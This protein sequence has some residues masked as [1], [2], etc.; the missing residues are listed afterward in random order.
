DEGRRRC[1]GS[2]PL[3]PLRP[4]EEPG[5]QAGQDNC[6][7][8]DQGRDHVDGP[9][10]ISISFT[11]LLKYR[12]DG[13]CSGYVLV[14]AQGSVSQGGTSFTA[15]GQGVVYSTD[16]THLQTNKTTA[17]ATRIRYNDSSEQKG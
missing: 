11:E 14:T 7:G 5:H 6:P 9:E 16:G 12:A 8:I 4:T 3:D 2:K 1:Q 15:S 17:Q 13:T 10:G